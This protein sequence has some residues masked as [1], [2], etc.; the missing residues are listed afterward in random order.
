[1]S[2][3]SAS[4][5]PPAVPS[6]DAAAGGAHSSSGSSS[7]LGDGASRY[8]LTVV[9]CGCDDATAASAGW[10]A[11]FSMGK[12]EHEW[13]VKRA[14]SGKGF[15]CKTVDSF[16]L[17]NLWLE[18][19]EESV[20]V[21]KDLDTVLRE[22]TG[23]YKCITN[24]G[25]S[26]KDGEDDDDDDTYQYEDDMDQ[27]IAVSTL[28]FICCGQPEFLC[29]RFVTANHARVLRGSGRCEPQ[30]LAVYHVICASHARR[31]MRVP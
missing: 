31:A 5:P 16:L 11:T 10:E 27:V 28:A 23:V 15:V 1:M 8:G 17:N 26:D 29:L 22:A 3:G 12:G 4:P 2:D 24:G 6:A 7:S 20:S 25:G 13:S 9:R 30:R 18:N 19:L 21:A 14:P